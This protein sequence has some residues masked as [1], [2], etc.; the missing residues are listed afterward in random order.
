L[1][2]QRRPEFFAQVT[3]AFCRTPLS[4]KYKTRCSQPMSCQ[5]ILEF[6][7]GLNRTKRA[8][9]SSI[10]IYMYIYIYIYWIA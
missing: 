8:R 9:S 2:A 4:L 5:T 7:L 1:L 10:Y 6:A 3:M